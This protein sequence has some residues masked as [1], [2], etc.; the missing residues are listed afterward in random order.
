MPA[1]Q[2]R[3]M[4]PR[5]VVP[6]RAGAVL[7]RAEASE[8]KDAY[9]A[10]HAAIWKWIQGAV[11]VAPHFKDG[12]PEMYF[13]RVGFQDN[14]CHH[15]AFGNLQGNRRDFDIDAL[16]P[17]VNELIDSPNDYAKVLPKKLEVMA[18]GQDQ[19]V[20]LMGS[21]APPTDHSARQEIEGGLWWHKFNGLPYIL[22]FTAATIFDYKVAHY[23]TVK[24]AK[25]GYDTK[26]TRWRKPA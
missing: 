26:K 1:A 22:G 12:G 2:P 19:N 7:Q 15:F 23:L 13:V 11:N 5:V 6:G 3:M 24:T 4:A 16:I 8:V 9:T 18:A 10:D 14:I 17:A 21:T 25:G 20:C